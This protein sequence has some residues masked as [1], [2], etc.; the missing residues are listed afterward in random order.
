ML[1]FVS[2]LLFALLF[3]A[4]FMQGSLLYYLEQRFHDDFGLEEWLHRSPFRVGG[5][6]YE[7]IANVA[8]KLEQRIKGE[9]LSKDEDASSHGGG[10]NFKKSAQDRMA[11]N[12]ALQSKG[13]QNHDTLQSV[14]PQDSKPQAHAAKNSSLN[15]STHHLKTRDLAQEPYAQNS[16]PQNS[17]SQ[18]SV[19]QSLATTSSLPRSSAVSQNPVTASATLQSGENSDSQ[20]PAPQA[21]E[22]NLTTQSSVEIDAK[23]S[24]SDDGKIRLNAGDEV[25]FMGDSL[26]QYVGMN[27]KKFFPKRSLRVIDLSKQSTGLASKKSFDWQKTLDT[28][29]RENGGVKLVVVLLGANDVWEYRAGGK[30]YGI[31]TPRWREFYASRVREIYDTAH[32]HGAGVLWL[33]MPCMQKPDFEEKTQLLNQIYAD[34]SMAL[35]GYFMQT[36]PLVCEKGVYKTYLQSGSKLVRVRQDDGIHMSKE[37]C[38]AVAKEILSRIEVE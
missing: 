11:E 20:L 16:A 6:I 13:V 14:K 7:K 2:T 29:L 31:K 10:E 33:A 18:N 9:D 28:A 19:S 35:G 25:L 17:T 12:Q 24:L 3:S 30:T 32:S 5:E 38:E 27:A 23:I 36:T 4:F 34:A 21:L 26:M 8:D 1:R 15:N 37:G 22:Q